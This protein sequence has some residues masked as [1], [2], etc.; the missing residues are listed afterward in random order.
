MRRPRPEK[1]KVDYDIIL[2]PNK[3]QHKY[4]LEQ[5]V[6]FIYDNHAKREK[7]AQIKIVYD[8]TGLLIQYVFMIPAFPQTQQNQG[9]PHMEL[10]KDVF[11]TQSDLVNSILAI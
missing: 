4:N 11:A 8:A 6:F 3:I 7:V 2:E 1:I 10:E 5:E 9:Q